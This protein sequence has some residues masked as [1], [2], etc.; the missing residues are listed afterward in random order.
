M[1]VDA[2]AEAIIERARR[3]TRS[4]AR[5]EAA[6][7]WTEVLRGEPSHP[8]ALYFLAEHAM[9]AGD[10]RRAVDMLAVA[11]KG[12]PQ[13]AAL[14]LAAAQAYARLG[15]STAKLAALDRA[16]A[17]DPYCY[18]ALLQK[19][20]MLEAQAPRRAASVYRD[21]LKITPPEERVAPDLRA[22]VAHAKRSVAE[23]IDALDA[24]IEREIA[25]I[26]ARHPG[27]SFE[28][29][30][31]CKDA[32]LGRTKIFVQEPTMLHFP[33]LPAISYFD[34]KEFPWLGELEAATEDMTEELV[35]LLREGDPDFIPYVNHPDGAPVNQ[36]S[37]LNRSKKW[38][39][40]FLWNDGA[41]VDEHCKRCP[42]TAAALAR[43]PLANVPGYAPAA[44]FSTL[45]AGA[46]I[47]PHTGVT[48]TRLVVHL[49]LIVPEGCFFRVGNETREWKRGEAWVFDDTIEHEAWNSSDKLRVIMIFDIWH[50]ALSQAERDLVCALLASQRKYY[51]GS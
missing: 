16:L 12:R 22:L 29:F 17:L 50:P 3:L 8:E 30:N 51:A 42:K 34:R 1:K 27:A 5:A 35:G 40:Y 41:R 47:P 24:H 4:G 25:S 7:A 21:A 44:F 45:D 15:D 18:P 49:P 2:P 32:M 13:D 20:A 39:A 19:A 23:N 9:R 26:R 6:A 11:Q 31:E 37:D 10:A 36:W 43:L 14:P 33:H 48:N 28:S 38:S 46:H